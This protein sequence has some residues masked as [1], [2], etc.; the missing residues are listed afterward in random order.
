MDAAI[1]GKA[2]YG[3]EFKLELRAAVQDAGI[4]EPRR[5]A[6]RSGSGAMKTGVPD[7]FDGVAGLNGD[8]VRRKIVAARPDV[9]VKALSL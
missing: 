1:I 7:P 3:V 2:A 4:P 5:I 6:G 9:D 8:E